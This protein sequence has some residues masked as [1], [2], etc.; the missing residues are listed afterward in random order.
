MGRYLLTAMPFTGHVAPLAA[1]ARVLVNRGHDVR[2]YTGSRFRAKVEAA[3]ARLIPWQQA[4]DFDENDLA[5]TF[6]RL[7]GKKGMQQMLVNVVDC[8]IAT[9]P[10]QVADLS[11]EWEREPWDA[12][13]A[14][15]VSIGA[16][17]FSERSGMPWAT[18]SV[19][20]LNLVGP[21]GPPSGMGLR[22]GTNPIMRTR[23]AALRGL[24]PLISRP[25]VTA[26]DR[27]QAAIGLSTRGR[28]MD[29]I[30]FSPTLIAASGSPLLDY[31]RTDRPAHVHFVGEVAAQAA[32][33]TAAELPPWWGDLD[34]RRVVLVTQGTQNIDPDDLVRP[35]LAAL[36]GRDVL[37]VATTG[38]AGRD[39][40]P[41]PVPANV[42]VMGFAPF[43]AL[44]P[45]VDLAITNGGWGGTIAMLGQGIPLVIAGGDLDKPE[46]AARVAWSGAGVNLRTGR[47]TASAV[48]AAADRV[49]AE[50]SFREAAGRVGA[51]LRTL[52]GAA[53]AAE[54]IEG[55]V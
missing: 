10:A 45:R 17:L 9:A 39:E 35:A 44:L 12:L 30:V 53:R 16:V 49:L 21:G 5:A 4:P 7:V 52:G 55:M 37:V 11:A 48:Q 32:P 41:F 50:P 6:P 47:P 13:A 22:P 51:E 33:G 34:G 8:F 26:L 46:V 42:R 19:V 23:D 38:V 2:F 24:V 36:Q 20:P 43:G 31:G 15:E 14:D 25:L 18:V 3:G 40:F 54:L 1:V 27:A 28:S 29:R